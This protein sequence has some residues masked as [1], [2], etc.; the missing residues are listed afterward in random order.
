MRMKSITPQ[1]FNMQRTYRDEEVLLLTPFK[2][3][4]K[5]KTKQQHICQSILKYRKLNT[6]HFFNL[7]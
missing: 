5:Q 3:K 6:K 7:K 1:M 4:T 2:E